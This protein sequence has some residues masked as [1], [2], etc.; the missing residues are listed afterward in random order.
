M[1]DARRSDPIDDRSELDVRGRIDLEHRASKIEGL[2]TRHTS[3]HFT[4]SRLVQVPGVSFAGLQSD[5]QL[6]GWTSTE[7]LYRWGR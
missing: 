2:G 1:S 4:N 5:H 6:V 3:L 7:D